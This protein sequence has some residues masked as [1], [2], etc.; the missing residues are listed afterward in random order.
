MQQDAEAP[1]L[2]SSPG[3]LSREDVER[4]YQA[5]GRVLLAYAC[6]FVR[7][8]P[9]AEDILH[10][11]FARLL[12]GDLVIAG[13]P[14]PYLCRAVRNAALNAGRSQRRESDFA[15][16]VEWLEAPSGPSDM[17]LAIERAIGT[18]PEDQREVVVLHV[19]G[20]L[21][22]QEIGD[23][24]AISPNTAASRYRYALAKLRDTLKPLG[25]E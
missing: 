6:S 15:A 11:V 16:C 1:L 20:S 14:L 8:V 13:G 10:Q 24:L 23:L 7:S 17:A 9:A 3:R 5:H 22:F 19:W 4:L 2:T 25:K 12:R 21:T 18:L